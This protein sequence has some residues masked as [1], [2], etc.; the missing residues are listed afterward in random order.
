MVYSFVEL[1]D[2]HFCY[3]LSNGNNVEAATLYAERFPNRRHPDR[4]MFMNIHMRLRQSGK[5]KPNHGGGRR[6]T[7]AT[8]QREER[9]LETVEENPSISTRRIAAMERVSHMTV[10]RILRSNL[11]YPYHLQRVQALNPEDA[12]PRMRFCEWFT[13]K[14]IRNPLFHS[15]VLFTDE[16]GFNRDGIINFHNN[17]LWADENPHGINESRHQQRF[18]INVWAGIVD[19][20]LIGPF[21][22]PR[23]LNGRSYLNFLRD[24]LPL[25]MEIVPLAVRQRIFFMHDG[26]PPHFSLLV[27]AYLNETY[28]NKWIG[29]GGP[30][31]WPARSPDLNPLDYYLW[32]HLKQYVYSVP[33]PD[34]QTLLHRIEEGCQQIR[35]NPG[36]FGRVRTSMRKRT[37]KCIETHGRHFEHLL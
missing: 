21:V 20:F 13:R 4:R 34:E 8:I 36:I 24:N 6:A 18:S 32:G 31:A 16:A 23:K 15:S 37:Q 19:E 12:V 22:L 7:V 9:I 35:Q 3:G 30:I 29:R 26:A 33:I 11:L 5:L 17:H 14:C 28:H 1:T 2:M 27:R 25:L 10:H